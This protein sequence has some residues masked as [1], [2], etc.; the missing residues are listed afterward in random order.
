MP[1]NTGSRERLVA[2]MAQLLWSQG[3]NATGLNQVVAESGAPKGSLYHYFPG[4]KEELAAAGL[5][6]AGKFLT[7]SIES[8]LKKYDVAGAVRSICRAFGHVLEDSG[9][10]MGCPAASITL[11]A[12]QTSEQI[13]KV[14][15]ELYV[16]WHKMLADRLVE[17]GHD[18]GRA[19]GLATLIL[20][21]VEGAIVLARAHQELAALNTVADELKLVLARPS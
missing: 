12:A 18:S 7:A 14:S 10:R 13:R 2:T 15:D 6:E 1:R 11:E 8:A 19:A 4:G 20:S 21:A 17:E 16:L 5:T 9:F 3:F